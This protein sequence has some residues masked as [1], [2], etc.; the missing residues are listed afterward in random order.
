[1]KDR[2]E[3]YFQAFSGK[4]VDK[5]K[6]LYH[7]EISLRDWISSAEGKDAVI[8]SNQRLFDAVTRISV[9][10]N[11]VIWMFQPQDPQTQY[12]AACEIVLE[13]THNDGTEDELLVV[14]VIELEGNK[15]KEIR[16]YLGNTG[17]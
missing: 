10:I 6:E 12:L 17:T 4:D 16:A 5:L 3:E 7:D 2:I 8:A 9:K 1:M 11:K 13:L 14:D 15:I